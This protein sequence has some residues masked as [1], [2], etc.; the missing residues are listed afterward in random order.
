MLSSVASAGN[1]SKWGSLNGEFEFEMMRAQRRMM[2]VHGWNRSLSSSSLTLC[3]LKLLHDKL[4][5]RCHIL[6][7]MLLYIHT[8]S[9]N[10]MSLYQR[11]DNQ[12][13]TANKLL[14][15]Q[16]RHENTNMAVHVSRKQPRFRTFSCQFKTEQTK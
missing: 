13:S 15:S 7:E 2:M 12:T 14:I 11:Q 10:V 1:M 9:K 8:F 3:L 4:Q 5:N 16:S 6:L